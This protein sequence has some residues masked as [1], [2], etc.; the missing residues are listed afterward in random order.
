[1]R[2]A[3]WWIKISSGIFSFLFKVR[4][5]GEER[6]KGGSRGVLCVRAV[7]F[8]RF[9][10]RFLSSYVVTFIVVSSSSCPPLLGVDVTP[11]SLFRV[12]GDLA[13]LFAKLTAYASLSLLISRSHDYDYTKTFSV[14]VV[15]YVVV[16]YV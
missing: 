8:T 14:V 9:A 10:G 15:C 5:R 6:E 2:A 11:F 13:L 4:E 1:M 12:F 7:H 3:L 16:Y